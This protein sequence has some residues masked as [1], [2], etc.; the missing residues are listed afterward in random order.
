MKRNH[1]LM[2]RIYSFL[3]ASLL[4][5]FAG[6]G[7]EDKA[8]DE[9]LI[10]GVVRNHPGKTVALDLREMGNVTPLDSTTIDEEGR[11][12]FRGKAAPD[13]LYQVRFEPLKAIGIF[14]ESDRISMEVDLED[15]AQ[16]QVGG[17]GKTEQLREFNI[18]QM[19]L[20]GEYIRNRRALNLVNRKVDQEKWREQEARSDKALMTY[21]DF[22]RDYA[23]TC[24]YPVLAAMAA[25][26]MEMDPNYYFLQNFAPRLREKA[27]DL[28]LLSVLEAK[29]LEVGNPF[30]RYEG[31]D[32]VAKNHR[33][34]E[35][36][37]SELRG[38][39]VVIQA[40][41]SYCEF[42]RQENTRI[43]KFLR[44]HPEEDF[45]L[46]TISIDES[47]SEW[48]QAIEEDQLPGRYHM[49]GDKGWD[50]DP[51]NFYDIASIP[52][53]YLLDYRGIIRSANVRAADIE[54]SFSEIM[55]ANRKP[56]ESG[57]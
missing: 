37:L 46:F 44:E 11:F 40:W 27:P 2:N 16:Y 53:T 23:D 10:E 8:E 32:I 55:K 22:L 43:S 29:L 20:F 21:R 24:R 15:L 49:R 12:V 35:I 9:F 5:V 30:M 3:F 25:L 7:G 41:A 54:S 39:V 45:A 52:T 38:K 28:A 50:S 26:T 42:S 33:G 13:A 4:L 18:R 17:N 31:E 36:A 1:D 6:C 56:D 48:K 51:F 47:E 19:R 34:E 14:P 57:S